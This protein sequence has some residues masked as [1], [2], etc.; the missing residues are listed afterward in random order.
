MLSKALGED[1]TTMKG[2][3]DRI[4]VTMMLAS[5]SMF[6]MVFLRIVFLADNRHCKP[7]FDLVAP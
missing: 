5:P 7:L 4:F 3:V 2:L 6:L 1:P